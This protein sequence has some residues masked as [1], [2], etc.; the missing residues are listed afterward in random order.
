MNKQQKRPNENDD[1][2]E[3]EGQRTSGIVIFWDIYIYEQI[4]NIY[5]REVV[6]EIEIEICVENILKREGN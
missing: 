4:S 6:I 2:D 5:K 3:G 1:E